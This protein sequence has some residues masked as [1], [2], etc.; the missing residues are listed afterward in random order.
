MKAKRWVWACASALWLGASEAAEPSEGEPAGAALT[1]AG[2]F[3]GYFH[4]VRAFDGA[5][6]PALRGTL[7]VRVTDAA[8]GKLTAHAVLQ[9]GPMNFNA[10]A[11]SETDTNGTRSVVLSGRGRIKSQLTLHVRE[12]RLWGT[13]EGGG[14]EETLTVDGARNRFGS[15]AGADAGPATPDAY[16][17]YYTVALPVAGARSSGRAQAAP[18][19]VGFLTLTVGNGGSAKI[20]GQLAD[21]TK[22]SL[23]SQLILIPVAGG[24]NEVAETNET[25][26][27]ASEAACIPVFKALAGKK[28][29]VGG[30]LWLRPGD[31]RLVETD[32]DLGWYVRWE[33]TGS[34]SNGKSDNGKSGENG[35]ELLLDACGGYYSSAA[36]VASNYTFSAA[37]PAGV[38]YYSGGSAGDYVAAALPVGLELTLSSGAFGLPKGTN[39]PQAGGSYD[40]SVTNAAMA[41]IVGSTATGLFKGLF[42]LYFDYDRKGK[43]AHYK[44]RVPYAGV[45]TPTRGE[46]FAELPLVRLIGLV[47][48]TEPSLRS[49]RLYRSFPVVIEG[50][51]PTEEEIPQ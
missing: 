3:D 34:R 42:N 36:A 19:G 6:A 12:D 7:R 1:T 39:P 2:T 45:L 24:T 46:A 31:A 25:A 47:K 17:G 35:F 18:Q 16:R 44:S 48:D 10:T 50:G 27:A 22:L 37:E 11:W 8:Q 33:N 26:R 4:S 29:W 43:Q 14:L 49:Y 38:R 13:L 5:D 30:L 20:A 32:R 28:G 51:Y 23:S 9:D 41:T 15:A 21:G 40:Y